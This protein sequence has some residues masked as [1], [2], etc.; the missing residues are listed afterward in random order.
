MLTFVK[1][2]INVWILMDGEQWEGVEREAIFTP[3]PVECLEDEAATCKIRSKDMS[4]D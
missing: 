3:C 1:H 4:K 2:M